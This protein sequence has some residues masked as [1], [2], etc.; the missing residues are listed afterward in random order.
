M[1][2]VTVAL[3]LQVD[4]LVGRSNAAFVPDDLKA[5]LRTAHVF[6]EQVNLAAT[7]GAM[8]PAAK[9]SRNLLIA[10]RTMEASVQVDDGVDAAALESALHRAERAA[11]GRRMSTCVDAE[12][13]AP[14]ANAAAVPVEE[15]SP[16]AAD[17]AATGGDPAPE[18]RTHSECAGSAAEISTEKEQAQ[19]AEAGG[20]QTGQGRKSE[21][22]PVA[23]AAPGTPPPWFT[24]AP[25]CVDDR[26][27]KVE[28]VCLVTLTDGRRLVVGAERIDASSAV[29]RGIEE[30]L[31][32]ATLM[33]GVLVVSGLKVVG[34]EDAR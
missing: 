20:T 15:A 31:D 11:A 3:E 24:A 7:S 29:G 13:A 27:L 32:P 12:R 21:L 5:L 10:E 8:K 2:F 26:V 9:I 23:A 16:A 4:C 33:E 1:S 17:Q 19:A 25:S 34:T 18:G 22:P 28:A 6:K 14:P 30:F